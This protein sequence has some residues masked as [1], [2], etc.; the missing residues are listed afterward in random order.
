MYEDA[1][2]LKLS[3][4]PKIWDGSNPQ[5]IFTLENNLPHVTYS[6]KSHH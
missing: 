4:P 3:P 6:G 5:K 2:E 1:K